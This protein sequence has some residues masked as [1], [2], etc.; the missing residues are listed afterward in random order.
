[1]Q[2]ISETTAISRNRIFQRDQQRKRDNS[3]FWLT[4]RSNWEAHLRAI[5]IRNCS[6]NYYVVLMQCPRQLPLWFSSVSH[7]HSHFS[8]SDMGRYVT[9]QGIIRSSIARQRRWLKPPACRAVHQEDQPSTTLWIL[10]GPYPLR[11]SAHTAICFLQ[12]APS[13]SLVMCSTE[14]M[15]PGLR[16]KSQENSTER[17]WWRRW[18]R[19][20]ELEGRLSWCGP[21]QAVTSW[22][23]AIGARAPGKCPPQWMCTLAA[24]TMVEIFLGNWFVEASFYQAN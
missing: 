23:V 10:L 17:R 4:G 15:M 6:C 20:I 24:L 18:G 7:R 14:D 1:M 9:K 8:W 2:N 12:N 11:K 13:I 3:P 16:Q 19:L 21:V 5:F 22:A